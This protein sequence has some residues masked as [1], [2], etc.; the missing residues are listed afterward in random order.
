M[1][2]D[3]NTTTAATPARDVERSAARGPQSRP[4][5]TPEE[6]RF[7][8]EQLHDDSAALLGVST[9]TV[10]GAV[11]GEKRKSLTLDEAKKLVDVF[12]TRK[13][14]HADPIEEAA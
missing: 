2:D 11:Y 13:A 3:E 8:V 5:A 14:E 10:A 12:L 6:V 1:A 7:T 9:H 4:E